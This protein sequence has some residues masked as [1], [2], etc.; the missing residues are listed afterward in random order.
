MSSPPA[1][2]LMAPRL[3]PARFEDYPQIQRLEATHLAAA[4]PAEEWPRLW[5]DS[6][7]WPRV[8]GAW[9]VGWLLED[10]AGRAVGSLTSLASLYRFRGQDLICASG[11]AWVAR[12]EYRG[13]APWLMEEFFNQP[14]VDLFISTTANASAEPIFSTYSSRVPVGDWQTIAYWVTGY[15]G[16]ARKAL[17][18]LGIPLAPAVACPGSAGLWLK[19]AL[20]ARALPAFSSGA[21]ISSVDKFDPRFDAFW[22]ELVRQNS[23]KLLAARDSRTLAWHYAIPMRRGRVWIFTAVRNGLLRAYCVL[24]RHDRGE[25]GVR[26]MRLIDYQTLEP[27]A[28]LLPELLRA[29]LRR[30]AAEGFYVLEHLGCGLPKMRTFDDF[31]PYRRKLPNWPF[32][33]HAADPALGVELRRPEAW[34]PS[35]FDGD[36]SID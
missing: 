28:D 35:T 23:D 17:Q 5:L 13:F 34:A 27:D 6:P 16:F 25:D 15:R 18:K 8:G 29:A 7:L 12:P 22:E 20:F 26:R 30:C 36:A 9:Q 1:T 10:A 3:R 4:L 24:N 11:R 33:Y 21:V 31:A 14:G 2:P 32:Y 19:D